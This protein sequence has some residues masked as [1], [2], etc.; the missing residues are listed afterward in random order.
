MNKIILKP[1]FLSRDT[2]YGENVYSNNNLTTEK[3]SK[4]KQKHKLRFYKIFF[5]KRIFYY[6]IPCKNPSPGNTTCLNLS[7][8]KTTFKNS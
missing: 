3:I 5:M 8:K 2:L 6:F 7:M 4:Y 1:T